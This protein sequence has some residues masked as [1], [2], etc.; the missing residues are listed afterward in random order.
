LGRGGGECPETTG[1]FS[2]VF[3][4]KKGG[5]EKEEE[6]RTVSRVARTDA[7]KEKEDISTTTI[8]I[9]T[10]IIRSDILRSVILL[11]HL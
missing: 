10:V 7:E 6:E 9:T 3:D 11:I 5:G 2:S 8:T 4:S 1:Q